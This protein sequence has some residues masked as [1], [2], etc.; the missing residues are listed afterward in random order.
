VLRT[1]VLNRALS[2][3]DTTVSA[4]ARHLGVD[5]HTARL[6]HPGRESLARATEVPMTANPKKPAGQAKMHPHTASMPGISSSSAKLLPR[7]IKTHSS[8]HRKGIWPD[9]PRPE[10]VKLPG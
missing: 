3:G 9:I 8:L 1:D 2:Y 4:L 6:A 5:W 10:A 7:I